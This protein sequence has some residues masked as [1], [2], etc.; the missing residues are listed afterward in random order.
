MQV[1]TEVKACLSNTLNNLISSLIRN[2]AMPITIL[3]EM[4]IYKV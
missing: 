1:N 3:T 4:I 2:D